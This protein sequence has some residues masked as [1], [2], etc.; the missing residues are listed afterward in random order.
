MALSRRNILQGGLAAL[1]GLVG[2]GAVRSPAFARSTSTLT[3]YG[4]RWQ[5][6]SNHFTAGDL[7]GPGDRLTAFGLLA[8]APDGPTVGEFHGSYTALYHPGQGV[9]SEVAT[10][11]QHTFVLEG[12]TLVGSGV[13][14]QALDN[15]DTFAIVGGTGQYAAARGTYVARQRPLEFGGDGTA[16]FVIT[17][18]G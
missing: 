4:R 18:L 5:V 11:E 1:G 12:G 17:I 9:A 16:E 7:P 13:G 8:T 6:A 3:L 2:V 14:T 15:V 10:L